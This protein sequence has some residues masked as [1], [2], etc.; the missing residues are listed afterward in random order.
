[1]DFTTLLADI[2]TCPSFY[3]RRLWE[4]RDNELSI[5]IDEAKSSP[6]LRADLTLEEKTGIERGLVDMGGSPYTFLSMLPDS[7]AFSLT[8]QQYKAYHV[9][10]ETYDVRD[11]DDLVTAGRLVKLFERSAYLDY[12]NMRTFDMPDIRGPLAHVG[13]FC[14]NHSIDVVGFGLPVIRQVPLLTR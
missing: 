1:M 5:I 10:N 2:D 12:I 3:L 7:R 4:P 8:W 11:K 6:S 13:V 14:L 9:T